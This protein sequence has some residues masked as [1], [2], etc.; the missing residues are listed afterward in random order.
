MQRVSRDNEINSLLWSDKPLSMNRLVILSFVLLV[1][2]ARKQYANYYDSVINSSD[3]IDTEQEV[4]YLSSRPFQVIWAD[5]VLNLR[6]G[7]Y[8]EP[9]DYPLAM[10]SISMTEESHLI[11]AHHSGQFLE[12]ED[13]DTIS[14]EDISHRFVQEDSPDRIPNQTRFQIQGLF[15]EKPLTIKEPS[16]ILQGTTFKCN[17][18]AI[19]LTYPLC[20]YEHLSNFYPRVF[21]SWEPNYENPSELY[22]IIIV[23]IFDEIVD[24]LHVTGNS[25]WVDFS[26][27]DNLGSYKALYVLRIVDANNPEMDSDLFG[28][29]LFGIREQFLGKTRTIPVH[30]L[31]YGYKSEMYGDLIYAEQMFK[32]SALISTKKAYQFFYDQFRVRHGLK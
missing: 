25:L 22:E 10:D 5:S 18:P 17:S 26:K 2:C 8:L 27:Y 4:N 11:L 15:S 13:P 32:L 6:S 3:S 12:F 20:T 31:K 23:N 28:F 24:T 16:R 30:F 1:S 7:L 21:I 14:I 29:E 19:G 9:M